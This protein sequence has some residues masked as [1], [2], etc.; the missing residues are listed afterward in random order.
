MLVLGGRS[1]IALVAVYVSI[2]PA[3]GQSTT[4]APVPRFDRAVIQQ[5]PNGPNEFRSVLGTVVQGEVRLTDATLLECLRFAYGITNNFQIVAPDWMHSTEY[6]FNVIAKAPAATALPELRLMLQNLIAE[7]FQMKLHHEQRPLEYLALSVSKNGLKMPAARAGSD[8]SDNA[9]VP[10][11]IS[12]N[13]MSMTQ[14]TAL[15]AEFL[16][17]P[18]LDSTGLSG[19]FDIKLHWTPPPTPPDASGPAPAAAASA[20][21][22]AVEDQLGLVL[23]PMKGP[24][25]V[26]VVDQAEKR[27]IDH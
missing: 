26:I 9:Q 15:L 19:W 10:G 21:F 13:S 23:Q 1:G 3:A 25:D 4:P 14:F 16:R 12:S 7:R 20:I 5:L 24:L 27:P 8:A 2:H 22:A 18:V 17:Q 11:R 6:R